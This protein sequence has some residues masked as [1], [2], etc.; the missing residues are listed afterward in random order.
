VAERT[1]AKD[2]ALTAQIESEVPGLRG[3]SLAFSEDARAT[4][5]LRNDGGT[6][7]SLQSGTLAAM[8]SAPWR[9]R[10]IVVTPSGSV[11]ATGTAFVVEIQEDVSTRVWLFKGT[12]LLT[13]ARG[14]GLSVQAPAVATIHRDWV[15]LVPRRTAESASAPSSAADPLARI[16]RWLAERKLERANRELDR[17]LARNPDDIRALFLRGDA[18]RLGGR[19]ES[20]LSL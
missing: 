7:V 9:G 17:H 16:R 15:Q 8:L 6:E 20:A 5:Q 10:F 11:E 14:S 1:E 12:L 4:K 2:K 19:P 3:I 13:P 18:Q